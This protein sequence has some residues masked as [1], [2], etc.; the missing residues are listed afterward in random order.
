MKRN[1]DLIKNMMNTNSRYSY[2]NKKYW[3]MKAF[4]ERKM[5]TFNRIRIMTM[6][7]ITNLKMNTYI[8]LMMKKRMGKSIEFQINIIDKF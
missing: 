6:K 3:N 4:R 7:M 8:I 2:Q 5:N 1:R